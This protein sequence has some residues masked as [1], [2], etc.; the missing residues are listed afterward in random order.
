MSISAA[1]DREALGGLADALIPAADGMPS[2]TEAGATGTLLDEVLRVRED[3]EEPLATLT[4][5]AAGR[6]PGAEIARLQAE[7]P[8]LFEALTTAIAGGYFMSEDVRERLGY[9]GQQALELVDDHDPAL[10]RPVIERG[11]IYRP[12]PG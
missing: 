5:A 3:L 2:A 1:I 12:T 4:E 10:L 8:E 9:P 7:A 6:D 11:T